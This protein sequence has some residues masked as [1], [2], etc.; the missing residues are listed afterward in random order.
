MKMRRWFFA[1]V[2]VVA[3]I[4]LAGCPNGNN[5]GGNDGNV[6]DHPYLGL[7][8]STNETWAGFDLVHMPHPGGEHDAPLL[9]F[10]AGDIIEI[11]GTVM[12]GSQV[13]I[14]LNQGGER[15]LD[16]WRSGGTGPFA[17]G[18]LTLTAEDVAAMTDSQHA[19]AA[20][21]RAGAA[22]VFVVEY[23][24]VTRGNDVLFDLLDHLDTLP[25]GETSRTAIFG[26]AGPVRTIPVHAAGPDAAV[27]FMVVGGGG[28]DLPP[29][30]PPPP[31][32]A[33]AWQV[34]IDSPYINARHATLTATAD[35]IL[36]SG[37]GTG[38]HSHNNS[39][40]FDLVGLRALSDGPGVVVLTGTAEAPII[41]KDTQGLN[42]NANGNV[43]DG[44]F[45]VTIPAETVLAAGVVDGQMWGG[46]APFLGSN[47]L[48]GGDVPDYTVTGITV[49]G[50]CIRVLLAD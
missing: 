14:N 37:R 45:T 12:T 42:P 32:G 15:W 20:R 9:A 46:P 13:G 24:T 39:M 19:H 29:P 35:G 6:W 8:V 40:A 4:A 48:S 38:E 25:L 17:S 22:A 30:P 21:V 28:G 34:V 49:D 33:D 1:A 18:P 23:L 2:A 36:V 27:S 5:N 43:V 50:T 31:P 16:G 47:D 10:Q 44:S 11:E 26:G 7:R 41:R 3:A